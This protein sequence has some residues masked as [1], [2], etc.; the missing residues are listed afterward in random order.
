M[1]QHREGLPAAWSKL[2]ESLRSRCS[3]PRA[4]PLTRPVP[5]SSAVSFVRTFGLRLMGSQEQKAS[6]HNKR[7]A[8]ENEERP[9]PAAE[10]HSRSSLRKFAQIVAARTLRWTEAHSTHADRFARSVC[11]ITAQ[12]KAAAAKVSPTTHE[13]E[14]MSHRPFASADSSARLS[15]HSSAVFRTS[16]LAATLAMRT[17]AR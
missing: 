8:C 9:G 12:A 5:P 4:E 13:S 2:L 11:A 7:T 6:K 1:M 14:A 16:F 15:V 10:A 3:S 17:R